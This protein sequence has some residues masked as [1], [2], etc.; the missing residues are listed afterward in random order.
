MAIKLTQKLTQEQKR[1]IFLSSLGGLL[2]FYDFTIYGFFAVYFSNQFFPA[3]DL[4][5][6][7]IE[8]YSVFVVGYIVRPIGG[9]IFSHIG[10]EIGRKT[11]MIITMVLMGV[12]SLG[13]G[14]CP[15]YAQIGVWAPILLL[16]FRLLQGLAIGGE[17][18][19]MIVYV[20]ESIPGRR[21]LAMGGVFAG[22][23]AGL[24]PGMLIDILITHSLT[25][26]QIN[27]FGWRIPFILG[28]M[29]CVIAYQIR[30]RLH[31]TKAFTMVHKHIK[32]PI[33]EIICNH[34]NKVLL[35]V[36][37]VS[38][39]AMPIILLL[40]FMPTY[41][42]NIVKFDKEAIGSAILV[43]SGV[44][45]IATLI[46]GI[47]ADRFSVIKLTTIFTVLIMGA[48]GL[49]YYM[50]A[51]R[52]NLVLALAVFA[53]IQG[54]LVPLPPILLSHLFPTQ[55]RL[56]GVA[57]SYNISF[58]LFGGLTPIIVT[59]LIEKTG[60]IYLSPMLC[61]GVAVLVALTALFKCRRYV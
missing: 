14:L 9:I 39:M 16:I 11:V 4:L 36:G 41:L 50:I 33:V 15:T 58:V 55:I 37:L 6:S 38:M 8:S 43:T 49:C 56:S 26:Q 47:L 53:V 20:T 48:A 5:V 10:D 1:I 17:L 24:I 32:L 30:R 3:K 61:L 12:S 44:T 34:W 18:P 13:L 42:I 31:E 7:I 60:Y 40:I 22:T 27:D 2:E 28:G 46:S 25:N 19:S 51:H 57:L 35:G 21:G 45:F 52:Y 29:L 23:V 59:E 54:A